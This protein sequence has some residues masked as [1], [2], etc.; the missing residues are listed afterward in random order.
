MLMLQ[1]LNLETE[2][3]IIHS[4]RKEDI[5]SH[6]RIA[7]QVL[8]I[9]SDP[10]T[11]KFVPGKKLQGIEHARD[12]IKTMIINNHVGKS[13]I[14]FITSK[15]MDSIVGIVDLIPPD[16]A[17]QHYILDNYPHFI[18]FYL[19]ESFSGKSIMTE[20]L[21]IIT[22][23]FFKQDIK[24]IAAVVNRH[25]AGAVKVLNRAGFSYVKAFD[26][27]QDLYINSQNTGNIS[28]HL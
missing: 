23:S 15:D 4:F 24:E 8:F 12:F 14:H 22:A 6:E 26:P 18:E 3:Y 2:K 27:L 20:L 21:P 25:N 17:R 13:H 28:D 16:I 1:P 11:L 10:F 9:F 19:S 7:E 5:E